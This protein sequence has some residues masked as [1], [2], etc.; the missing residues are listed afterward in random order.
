MAF[1]QLA[2]SLPTDNMGIH[3][4]QEMSSVLGAS[5]RAPFH[6]PCKITVLV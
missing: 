1:E 3:K 2:I 6:H 4:Q 5:R